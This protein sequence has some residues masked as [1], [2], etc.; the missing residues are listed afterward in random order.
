VLAPQPGAVIVAGSAAGARRLR[1][2]ATLLIT[3][4]VRGLGLRLNGHGI[5]LPARAGRLRVLLDAA[6]GLVVGENLLWVTVGGR[7]RNPTVPFVVGHRDTHAL[8]VHLQL[9]AGTLPAATETLRVPRTGIDRISVTLNGAPVRVPPDGGASGRIGLDLPELG[10]VHW[11]PN[12]V[13]V[14]LIMIDGRVADWART[15][16]LDPRRDVAIARLDGRAVVGRTVTLDASRSLI[17]PGVHQARGVRWV[18]LRRPRLS[19][20]RLGRPHGTR[21]TLRPD[22]PGYY[23]VGLRV[24]CT[25]QRAA[26]AAAGPGALGGYDV[27]TVPAKYAEP[28]VP[29]NTIVH[30]N[31]TSGVQVG[32]DFYPN[33]LVYPGT[34]PLQVVVLDRNTLELLDNRV[35]T[36]IYD[37]AN[38]LGSFLNSLSSSDLVIV[39]TATGWPKG[40]YVPGQPQLASLDSALRKIGGS[41]PARWTLSAS[42]CWSGATDQC[43]NSSWQRGSYYGS[44]ST[45]SASFTEIGVP[46]MQVGQAWR[47]TEV[48]NGGEEGRIVGYLTQGTD[49]TTPSAYTVINGGPADYEAV[50]TCAPPDCDVQIGYPGDAHYATYPSPGPN[51]FQVLE[52]DRTTLAPLLNRTVTTEADLLSAL[53]YAGGQQQLGHFVGSMDDQ[54][55]V[56]IRSVGDGYVGGQ[57]GGGPTSQAPL[58]QYIDELGG[59]PDLLL[60]SMTGHYKYALVGAATNLPWRN[61]V[62][63]ESS[64]GIPGTPSNPT[65]AGGA[66]VQTGKISGVVQRDR[67]GLYAP[68]AGDPVATTTNS[69]LYRILYQPAQPWP[70]AE[71]TDDLHSIAEQL[72]LTPGYPDVRSAYYK[73]LYG[74]PWASLQSRLKDVVC[75]HP[76]GECGENSTFEKLKRELFDEFGWVIEVQ[77]F[78][79][80]LISPFTGA[81]SL[82]IQTV[83]NDVKA[84]VP[85]PAATKVK[86]SWLTIM[87][88]VMDLASSFA[89]LAH[90]DTLS[91]VFGLIGGAGTMATDVMATQT[92]PNGA[93]APANTLTETADNLAIKLQD[94]VQSYETWVGQMQH[95][96]VYDY[97]KLREVGLA[98]LGDPAWAWGTDTRSYAVRAL[99]GNTRASAYSALVP[100]VWPGYNLK[101]YPGNEYYQAYSNDTATLACDY[102]GTSKNTHQFPF[103]NATKANQFWWVAP[104]ARGQSPPT[105]QQQAI[106]TFATDGGAVDQAW[107]FAQLNPGTWA[108]HGGSA[109]T[110][111]PPTTDLTHYIYGADSSNADHGAYQFAPVWWRNTY[112]PPSHTICWRLPPNSSPENYWSTQYPPP[113]IPPPPP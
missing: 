72:G 58:L 75:P 59:T 31:N 40:Y 108:D 62:A 10:H 35:Y 1:L 96:A 106:T 30:K 73:N 86:M 20:A 25:S 21:I 45:A 84:S 42:H 7:D 16:R 53:S 23:Q 15:F 57:S 77:Q 22:V 41:V 13:R 91:S 110:A 66:S 37:V 107:V 47:A 64:T 69:E 60:N 63:L 98:M 6:D 112:N 48:Q 100:A 32:N 101:P 51:G 95:I 29:V 44:S 109:R 97:G 2:A 82:D 17:V 36:N 26:V 24:G 33:N 18:L 54:R 61:S 70:Y 56:I 46:G 71:D 94:Q 85:V 74:E 79:T 103:A 104:P 111:T 49:Q 81:N 11:G 105:T 14:R 9:G 68:A 3:R 5:R 38:Y 89:S 19:H 92:Q 83:Y 76:P 34:G 88:D 102:A 65:T 39:T 43:A 55:L 93:P 87:S 78:G 50:D 67:T 4:R 12:R 52:L 99:R 27:A 28:L 90:Q 113:N 8:G 80:N